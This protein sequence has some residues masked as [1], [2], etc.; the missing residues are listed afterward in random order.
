MGRRQLALVSGIA[1]S[2]TETETTSV[3]DQSANGLQVALGNRENSDT[4]GTDGG[5]NITNVEVNYARAV[6]TLPEEYARNLQHPGEVIE[7]TRAQLVVEHS[8]SPDAWIET[9][10]GDYFTAANESRWDRL[11]ALDEQLLALETYVDDVTAM[12]DRIRIAFGIELNRSLLTLEAPVMRCASSP[13]LDS[14]ARSVFEG[15]NDC[16]QQ[17]L[18]TVQRAHSEA[19]RNVSQ[20]LV[21]WS[22]E[23]LR[24]DILKCSNGEITNH[25]SSPTDNEYEL[26]CISEILHQVHLRTLLLSHTAEQLTAN[27]RSLLGTAKADIL[28][29]AALLVSQ[30]KASLNAISILISNCQE[31]KEVVE[32]MQP[33]ERQYD[34]YI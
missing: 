26:A 20:Q 13:Q 24:A 10:L 29:C 7:G 15:G 28:E 17:R 11:G 27:A 4:F 2:A 30:A 9:I 18:D 8:S 6:P 19:R 32:E 33:T 23:Q 3:V 1:T 14:L 5:T 12:L 22:E 34:T 21:E 25:E 16:V 31:E